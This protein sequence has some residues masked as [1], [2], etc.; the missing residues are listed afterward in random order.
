MT[1]VFQCEHCHKKVKAPDDAA[2]RRGKCPHCGQGSYIPAPVSEEDLVPL[3]EVD[4][5]EEARRRAEIE[6]LLQA[7]R[8][9]LHEQSAPAHQADDVPTGGRSDATAPEQLYHH[10]VNYVLD[11]SNG[12]LERAKAHVAKLKAHGFAAHQ[13]VEDFQRGKAQEEVLDPL[14]KRVL[15]GYLTQL[16]SDLG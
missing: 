8:E 7:E 6:R 1:I 16:K 2:G 9:L 4:E 3:A 5:Q 11:M 15:T 10:V 13:A 14:P 12:N